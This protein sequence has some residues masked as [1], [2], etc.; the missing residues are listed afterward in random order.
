VDVSAQRTLQASDES[1][2]IQAKTLSDITLGLNLGLPLTQMA[3]ASTVPAERRLSVEQRE[4]LAFQAFHTLGVNWILTETL[5]RL[6]GR[7][8]PSFQQNCIPNSDFGCLSP[9]NDDEF[10]SFASGHASFAFAG[11]AMTC[12][13]L[14]QGARDGLPL[15]GQALCPFSIALATSTAYFRVRGNAHW[16]SDVLVGAAM[17]VLSGAVISPLV[18]GEIP[19]ATGRR[20]TSTSSLPLRPAFHPWLINARF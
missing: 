9:A 10:K 13:Q 6:S 15:S 3:L 11:A 8:R 20:E 14:H 16:L 17:G 4:W 7:R 19:S 2:Q 5:K 12:V 18:T 1:S